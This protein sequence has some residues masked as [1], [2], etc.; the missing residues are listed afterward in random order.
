MKRVSRSNPSTFPRRA[1][2][3]PENRNPRRSNHRCNR[4]H[5]GTPFCGVQ[6]SDPQKNHQGNHKPAGLFYTARVNFPRAAHA[7]TTV[8]EHQSADVNAY[9]GIYPPELTTL[10]RLDTGECGPVADFARNFRRPCSRGLDPLGIQPRGLAT[11]L[12][13]PD[14]VIEA[15]FSA[16]TPYSAASV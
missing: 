4:P 12:M 7:L 8:G 3:D 10:M 6:R 11:R 2:R 15:S 1:R 9:S 13:L 14:R 5:D 16:E